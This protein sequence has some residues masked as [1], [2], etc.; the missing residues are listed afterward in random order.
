MSLRTVVCLNII[1][2][3]CFLSTLLYILFPNVFTP[4]LDATLT[5][6][7]KNVVQTRENIARTVSTTASKPPLSRKMKAD[8]STKNQ[9]NKHYT[10]RDFQKSVC[11]KR[12]K[13]A[14]NSVYHEEKKPCPT[15]GI[16]TIVPVGRTGNQMWEYSSIWSIAKNT[17]LQPYLP[18]CLKLKLE[19]VFEKM[20]FPSLEAIA[21]CPFN[22]N[23]A[24]DS[25]AKLSKT[26]QNIIIPRAKFYIDES[27]PYL[28]EIVK[29]FRFKREFV[30]YAQSTLRELKSKLPPKH[31]TF[32]GVHVRRTDYV[33]YLKTS[34]HSKPA[35]SQYFQNAMNYFKKKFSN[36]IFI[37]V[38][39]DPTWCFN[40]F[41]NLKD[42]FVPSYKTNSSAADD[43]ALMAACNHTIF[44]YGTF[45][46]WGAILAGGHAI[47]YNGKR[48]QPR[49]TQKFK[50]WI[51]MK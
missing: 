21:D 40:Q 41:G 22:P 12:F 28:K 3:I 11:V 4:T 8:N 7:N 44:D 6:V 49:R 37:Y 35:T 15:K 10:F 51:M 25:S 50:N 32:I 17:G 16:V 46:E 26:K 19:E 9:I 38:S 29:E 42:V 30:D 23:S 2:L 36:C 47:F 45:G 43:L 5:G 31:Y 33:N 34:Y 18:L 13:P 27:R 48:N 20:P 14:E 24:V 39:D 1:T